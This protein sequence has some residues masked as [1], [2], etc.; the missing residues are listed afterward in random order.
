MQDEKFIK[1]INH[2]QK[3][4]NINFLKQKIIFEI[5]ENEKIPNTLEFK[6]KIKIL[7]SM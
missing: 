6:N 7:K 5:L 3:K 2:L 1:I 4:Y